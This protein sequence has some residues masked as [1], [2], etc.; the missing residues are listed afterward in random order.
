MRTVLCVNHPW[1]N[2]DVNPPRDSENPK[3][4]QRKERDNMLKNDTLTS[5]ITVLKDSP[6]SVFKQAAKAQTGI[7]ILD[8]NVPCGVAISVNNYE[9]MVGE[10]ERILDEIT[11]LKAMIRLSNA[12]P[13]LV[14]DYQ[15][16]GEIALQGPVIDEN[17]GW[18]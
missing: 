9:K 11:E 18:E 15:V 2:V 7:Y 1:Q 10:N 8:H 5:D 12:A 13:E 3:S 16:R 17:D 6:S 14:S 4:G